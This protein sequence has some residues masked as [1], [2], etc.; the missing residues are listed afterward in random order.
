MSGHQ[1]RATGLNYDPPNTLTGNGSAVG[2][3]VGTKY[4][5]GDGIALSVGI[6]V[7][8]HLIK[9]DPGDSAFN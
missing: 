4:D 6:P 1:S 7:T 2:G 5:I 8:V 3:E 9:V